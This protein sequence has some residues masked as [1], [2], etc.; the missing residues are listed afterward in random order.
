MVIAGSKVGEIR[1]G[2]EGRGGEVGGAGNDPRRHNHDLVIMSPRIICCCSAR[3]EE[4]LERA[5][6]LFNDQRV[7]RMKVGN[8]LNISRIQQ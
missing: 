3:L 2:A 1:D 5:D 7:S 4:Q 6:N 8:T